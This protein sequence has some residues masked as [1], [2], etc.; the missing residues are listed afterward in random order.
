MP[1][2]ERSS[3][4]V[5]ARAFLPSASITYMMASFQVASVLS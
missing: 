2:G 5:R 3:F 4:S 1:L